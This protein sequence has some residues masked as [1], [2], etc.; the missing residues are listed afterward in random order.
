[1]NEKLTYEQWREKYA[2][3]I[4]DETRR[5]LKEIHG[6]DLDKEVEQI[7]R[8]DYNFYCNNVNNG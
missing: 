8:K 1:M 5:S 7:L 6:L 4:S 2:A 3:V